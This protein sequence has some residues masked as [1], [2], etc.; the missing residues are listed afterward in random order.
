MTRLPAVPPVGAR[1]P[2]RVRRGAARRPGGVRGRAAGR[3]GDLEDRPFFGPAG[4]LLDDALQEA[5]IDRSGV[6]VT[7]A[8]KH[9][10][11]EHRGKRRI[12]SA[13]TPPRSTPASRDW[14]A[15]SRPPN[16]N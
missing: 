12:T 11:F 2:D 10:K 14:D 9:F 4:R 3:Q 15:R 1:D 7:N 5:G 8:V 6:Y 13:R 16:P